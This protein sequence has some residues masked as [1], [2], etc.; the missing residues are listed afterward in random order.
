MSDLTLKR[1]SR[2]L[3]ANALLDASRRSGCRRFDLQSPV[4]NAVYGPP[5]EG[6]PSEEILTRFEEFGRTGKMPP[7]MGA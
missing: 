7:D 4:R 6:C 2:V 3:S 5:F 1:T